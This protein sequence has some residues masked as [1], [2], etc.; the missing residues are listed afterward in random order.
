MK[1]LLGKRV[2]IKKPVIKRESLIEF[3]P[4]MEAEYEQDM[5]KKYSQLEVFAVGNTVTDV[6]A[7]DLVYIGSA[8]AHAEVLEI[9]GNLYF[10]VNEQSISIIW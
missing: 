7:G 8:I 5:M 4:A 2:L 9:E 1:A 10:M 3:T 6:K